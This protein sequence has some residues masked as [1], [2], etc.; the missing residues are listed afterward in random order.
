MSK[1][2]ARQKQLRKTAK[3]REAQKRYNQTA[4]QRKLAWKKTEK[5][6][7]TCIYH[8]NKYRA[9]KMDRTV[10]WAIESKIKEIYA[11]AARLTKE[12]GIQFHVDHVIPLRGERVSGLH[13]ESN[14]QI[15]PWHENLAKSNTY[16]I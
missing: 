15:I 7:A 8:I 11:E 12:T 10:A 4:H 2:T 5:G 16:D 13:V 1:R 9:A 3:G 6:R 14:L